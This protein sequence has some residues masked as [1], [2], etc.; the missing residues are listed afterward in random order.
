MFIVRHR[1]IGPI[2]VALVF[3]LASAAVAL[4]AAA[5]IPVS[6]VDD[7]G[8]SLVNRIGAVDNVVV[9]MGDRLDRILGSLAEGHPPAPIFESL[10]ATRSSLEVLIGTIDNRICNTDGVIGSGDAALADSDAF[11][12]DASSTGILNQLSSVR[13]VIGEANGRLIRIY[14]V[15]P[16]GLPTAELR[17]ALITVRG[18]AVA[19]FEAI[20]SRLGDA[21]H[22]PSPCFTL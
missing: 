2:V 17:S 10:V 11:A 3:L 4:G 7:S 12:A 8:T 18:H 16:P 6:S 5:R 13:G 21:I 15:I 22:P 20:G 1:A 9:A 14:G 19:D